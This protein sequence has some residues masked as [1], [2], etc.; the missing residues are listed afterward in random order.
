[1][2]RKSSRSLVRSSVLW[3]LGPLLGAF[4]LFG[5][6]SAQDVE[7]RFPGVS[8]GLLY[9]GRTQPTVAIAPFR[10]TMGGVMVAERAENIV[11]RD[12]RHSNR[13]RVVDS[14][15]SAFSRDEVDYELWDQLGADW[16]VTGH[17]EGTG[18][19]S[20]LTLEVHDVIYREV[21]DRGRFFLPDPAD[22]DFRMAAHIASDAVV[23]WVFEEPGIAASRIMFA[24]RMEDGSQDLW[25]LDSDGE[26]LQRLTRDRAGEVGYPLAMSPAWS[27]DGRRVAYTSYQSGLPRIYEMNLETGERKQVPTPRDGDY[28]TPSYTP[29]GRELAFAVNAG[30]ASGLFRYNIVDDCCFQAI[31][32]GRWEDIS[33]SYSPDGREL[34]FNSN[35]LGV[36]APQIYRMPG[37]GGQAAIVSPYVYDRPGYYTSPEWSP[38]GDRIAYHGRIEQRGRHHILVSELDRR[39]R[40]VQ[41]TREGNNED[42][43]WAPDGRHLVY[44]GE[45][46]WGRGLFIVDVET[47]ATRTLISGM[48]ARMPAWSPS[49]GS[50]Y[51]VEIAEDG[52]ED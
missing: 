40:V 24:R 10:A 37:N 7:E 42:P 29:D 3:S 22:S 35:R 16:L 19:G 50:R 27:P 18:R 9:E 14:I 23:E 51:A 44:V 21:R 33:P 4:T 43:S 17:V 36:G 25:V 12:L 47:G 28:I 1:M 30:R 46:N 32:E 20:I 2:Q 38:R 31:T 8:L 13:F 26:N 34:A 39:R 52:F 11:A 48:R 6:L 5:G 41:L 15:P 45:R 49:L